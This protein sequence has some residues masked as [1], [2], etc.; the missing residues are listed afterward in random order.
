MT[1]RKLFVDMNER[2]QAVLRLIRRHQLTEFSVRHVQYTLSNRHW[3]NTAGKVREV[4][5][6]LEVDGFIRFVEHRPGTGGR[7]SEV[8]AVVPGTLQETRQ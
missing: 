3:A 4:L 1:A 6:T 8:Y 2:K 5:E 7:T